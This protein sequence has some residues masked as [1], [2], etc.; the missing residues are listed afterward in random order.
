MYTVKTNLENLIIQIGQN[1]SY[2]DNV[3]GLFQNTLQGIC[4]NKASQYRVITLQCDG[5]LTL[6]RN[7]CT[8]GISGSASFCFSPPFHP[9]W[10]SCTCCCPLKLSIGNSKADTNWSSFTHPTGHIPT[11]F[12][13]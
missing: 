5:V 9:F 6:N 3:C 4:F 7:S 8:T 13:F 2:N 12:I 11:C 1:T 10:N